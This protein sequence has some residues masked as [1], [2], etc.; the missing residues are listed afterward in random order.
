MEIK[1]S[2][3]IALIGRPNVGKST[4]L[5]K[6]AGE[7][8]AIVSDKPQTTRVRISAALVRGDTQ[9]VFLDTPGFHKPKNR[10][11]EYMIK[12]VRES[13]DGVDASVLLVEPAARVGTPE[14]LLIERLTDTPTVLAINK[15]DTV[16]KESLLAII[17]MYGKAFKF[18]A[19]VP[20][21]ARNG[22]GVELLFDELKPFI[23]EGPALYPEGQ[24][25]DQPERDFIAEL[26]REKLLRHLDKEV[27]HGTAVV[28]EALRERDGG[29]VEIDVVILCE[30]ASHKG[31]IIGRNGAMLKT[32]GQE[33]RAELEEMYEGPVLF[34]SW[35]K[36]R[37]DWRNR[38]GQLKDLGFEM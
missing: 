38:P 1:K 26:V 24:V 16:K 33:M 35:V 25:T 9:F 31:I 19:V 6:L 8:L 15:I 7:K 29:L 5:N 37:E 34:K 27:P 28:V 22:D 17:D 21:S 14:T 3:L 18:A 4:L 11:G 13:T 10:L 2:G 12:T 30:K 36:V 20:L 23:P 32:V